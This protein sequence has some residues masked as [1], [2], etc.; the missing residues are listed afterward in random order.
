MGSTQHPAPSLPDP[1]IAYGLWL[2]AGFMAGFQC[3]QPSSYSRVSSSIQPPVSLTSTT[4]GPDH[5]C[6]CGASCQ[7]PA[8]AC[9]CPK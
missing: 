1:S 8:G 6:S 7:C 4:S 2:M 3:S 5:T 9:Q